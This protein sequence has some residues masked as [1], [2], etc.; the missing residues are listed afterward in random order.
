VAR[1]GCDAGKAWH[2]RPVS[3]DAERVRAAALDA[4]DELG[5]L[6]EQFVVPEGVIY[7]DGNSL[8]ALPRRTQARLAE[9]V[10]EE[11]GH[12]LVTSWTAH[13]WIDL[14]RRIAAAVAP[15]I[16]ASADEV[17]VADSTSVNLFKLLTAALRL[18]PGRRVI[19][20]EVGNFPTD[21]YIAQGL[22][23]LLP[24]VTLRLVNRAELIDAAAADV[25][26]VTL[27]HV[28]FR[29]GEMLDAPAI[30]AAAHRAGAVALWDLSHS[31]GVVPVHLDAWGV[32][33]AVGCG[34]KYLSGGPG[35][36]A[37]AFVARE[38]LDT[39]RQPLWGWLG[40]ANPF[41]F[42]ASYEPAPSVARLQAGTPPILSLA[43]LQCGVE[44][45][46]EA[47]VEALRRKS[48]RLTEL[49]IRLIEER[50]VGS[51]LE[52]VTPADAGRR[53]SHVSLRYPQ[54][55]AVARALSERRVVVDFR[56]PDIVRFGFAPAYL[57][58]VDVVETVN[59]LRAVMEERTW[60]RPDLR[61]RETVT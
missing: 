1:R 48:L 15:L 60:E 44:L 55:Y 27:T 57:R 54:A 6:R 46:R 39:L 50:R 38:H 30:T 34:Y 21:L 22:A 56:A 61:G 37:F 13:G 23:D 19:L 2:N 3:D 41:A 35:A 18:R 52:P 7:L 20:S 28:D 58:F 59:H 11:W 5:W 4:E 12:D 14:P 36:P 9:V 51:D 45:I 43:A 32:D 40:H 42:T 47:G 8:G 31:A 29:T 25:A 16:G 24:G 33:L 10:S 17:A 53:G 26:V 49:F